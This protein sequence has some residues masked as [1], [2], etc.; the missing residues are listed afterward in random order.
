M[1]DFETIPQLAAL[2]KGDVSSFQSKDSIGGYSCGED[3]VKNK[4]YIMDVD[5]LKCTKNSIGCV[6]PKV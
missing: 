1:I 6:S 5:L 4:R 2:S 3:P